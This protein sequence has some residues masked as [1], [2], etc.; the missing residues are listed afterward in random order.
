MEGWRHKKREETERGFRVKVFSYK[1]PR[2]LHYP[3]C[4]N[5]KNPNSSKNLSA[6]KFNPTQIS[7]P[8]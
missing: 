1:I 6:Q 7:T 8:L 5:I 2:L 4:T 3:T